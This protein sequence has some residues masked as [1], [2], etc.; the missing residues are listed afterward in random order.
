M[1]YLLLLIILVLVV[2]LMNS[3]DNYP[4]IFQ[5]NLE[6]V[7]DDEGNFNKNITNPNFFEN[8]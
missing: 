7:F 3:K 2:C 4:M 6:Y 8:D 5:N 1:N